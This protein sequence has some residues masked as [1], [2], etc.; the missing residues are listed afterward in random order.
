MD[1]R[2]FSTTGKQPI[3]EGVEAF[4][5]VHRE[6]HLTTRRADLDGNTE[7]ERSP[8]T[9]LRKSGTTSRR[10]LAVLT[11]LASHQRLRLR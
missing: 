2:R 1:L 8:T 7:H 9:A 10:P 4:G 5:D 3:K 11:D 6:P